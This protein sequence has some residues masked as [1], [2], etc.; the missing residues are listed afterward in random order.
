MLHSDSAI[1]GEKLQISTGSAIFKEQ[2]QLLIFLLSSK[3]TPSLI[4][5]CQVGLDR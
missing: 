4:I 5:I 1:I 3:L 2:I